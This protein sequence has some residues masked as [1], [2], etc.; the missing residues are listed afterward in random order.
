MQQ[1]IILSIKDARGYL[2]RSEQKIAD[3][4]LEHSN[5]VVTL[6]AQELAKRAESSPAAIIR[7]CRSI[8]INGFTDL[9]I[10][11][12][13]NL[14]S[15]SNEMYTEVE[16]K[17]S[18]AA[19]KQKLNLRFHH[20]LER[21]ADLLDDVALNAALF[22]VETAE[23]IFVYGLGASSLVAQDVYQKF[24]RLG[25]NVFHSLDQHLFASIL[26][27]TDKKSLFI[28]I[29]NAGETSEVLTLLEI[30]KDNQI[31]TIGITQNQDSQL[32]RNS[33]I[34]LLTAK[35]EEAALRSAATA[36]L[37]A[38]LYI[39]D[40]LFFMYASKNYDATLQKIQTSRDT[41]DQL[42]RRR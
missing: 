41:I 42:K 13:A 4:I 26:A 20:A 11:L 32:A 33:D 14:G 40:V 25:C 22:E 31:K 30:A 28:G 7:F 38:Q 8:N 5:E 36:S 23:I 17:E 27:T 9:K 15:R 1:N 3:Y 21:T 2:P 35:G 24:I 19:I 37:I 18:T 39:I 6:S 12:S 10:L 34:L 16:E 29:S